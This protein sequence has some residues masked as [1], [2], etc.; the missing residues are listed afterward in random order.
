MKLI[1]NFRKTN[2]KFL[3]IVAVLG[4]IVI[5]FL[6]TTS[7]VRSL[8]HCYDEVNSKHTQI[9]KKLRNN[10]LIP[11]EIKKYQNALVQEAENCKY[12]A[13]QETGR[14]LFIVDFV[15][16]LGFLGKELD[17]TK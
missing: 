16:A 5:F 11:E 10:A 15:V 3:T 17:T 8:T 12:Q 4:L 14:P 6:I 1:D 13:A 7:V 9:L 2:W